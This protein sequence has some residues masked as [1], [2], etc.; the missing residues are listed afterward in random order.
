M[1]VST[2]ER[3]CYWWC[4]IVCIFRP[5]GTVVLGRPYVLFQFFILLF[6]RRE[7]SEVRGP[8]SAKFCHTFGSMLNL[9]IPVRKF[10]GLPSK[11]FWGEK[12]AKF[13]PILDTFPLWARISPK[14]IEIS[15]IWKPDALQRSFPRSTKKFGELWFTNYGD[16]EVQ[17][18][19]ENRRPYSPVVCCLISAPIGGAAPRNFY[20]PYRMSKFC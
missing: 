2:G 15:K 14:R 4:T 19:P 5:L 1:S 11:K 9:Q 17:L 12:H 3:F 7:I 16:L 6:F 13:G 8:I 10:G 20:T 18:Y